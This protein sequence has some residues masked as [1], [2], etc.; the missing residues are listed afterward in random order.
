MDPEIKFGTFCRTVCDYTLGNEIRH[1]RSSRRYLNKSFVFNIFS[2]C[3][4]FN[5]AIQQLNDYYNG[6][7]ATV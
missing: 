6:I 4:I 5:K 2:K 3:L 7:A 1:E